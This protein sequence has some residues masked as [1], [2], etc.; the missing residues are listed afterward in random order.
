VCGDMLELL[1]GLCHMSVLGLFDFVDKRWE[2]VVDYSRADKSSFSSILFSQNPVSAACHR[3]QFQIMALMVGCFYAYMGFQGIKARE[4]LMGEY[5]FGPYK[6]YRLET[7]LTRNGSERADVWGPGVSDFGVLGLSRCAPTLPV[8]QPSFSGPVGS[9]FVVS[10]P[11]GRSM[12]G[13]YLRSGAVNG[14]EPQDPK[15]FDVWAT[16]DDIAL[17][18]G[19]CA[20]ARADGKWWERGDTTDW[21]GGRWVQVGSPKWGFMGFMRDGKAW[22]FRKIGIEL[23]LDRGLLQTFILRPAPEEF[24][25]AHIYNNFAGTMAGVFTVVAGVVS[26]HFP[27]VPPPP[28][29]LGFHVGVRMLLMTS[30]AFVAIRMGQIHLVLEYFTKA[31][32]DF[33]IVAMCLRQGPWVRQGLAA[34]VVV[35]FVGSIM[36]SLYSHSVVVLPSG[37]GM[38]FFGLSLLFLRAL[39]IRRSK[40]LV[41]EDQARYDR[42]YTSLVQA[43]DSKVEIEHLG[44]VVQMIGLDEKNNCQQYNHLLVSMLP[45]RQR[46]QH[47]RNSSTQI[48]VNPLFLDLDRVFIPGRTDPDS[49]VTSINQLYASAAIS[50]KLMCPLIKAWA[51]KSDGMFKL[52]NRGGVSSD[53]SSSESEPVFVKWNDV[54]GDADKMQQ[55]VFPTLKRFG[56][57]VEKLLRSYGHDPSKLLDICRHCIIFATVSDLT[58]A[59][60]SIITDENVRVERLKNRLSPDHSSDETAGYRDVCLN[61]RVVNEAALSLGVDTHMCE[62]QLVL[63]DF[64]KLRTAEGHKRYVQARNHV[65]V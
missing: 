65:G 5:S 28:L 14:S 60:G 4:V 8:E 61:L 6:H 55:I 27:G 11:E 53:A 2:L 13:W 7:M 52:R 42:L 26:N 19:S 29:V 33:F 40:R 48:P 43:E 39:A 51:E 64:A 37:I 38:A 45:P 22:D 36:L 46:T 3:W 24:D 57:A 30:G 9:S 50:F 12:T 35:S 15:Y 32:P 41:R 25:Y 54:K 49:K 31:V 21:C 47:Y 16:N 63:V 1:Q 62:V 56:R 59:L 20:L 17:G 58:R 18:D 10:F 34:I 44:K 23:P